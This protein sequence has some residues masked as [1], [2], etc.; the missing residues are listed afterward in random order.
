MEA[1]PEF[2]M[3]AEPR[4]SHAGQ[5]LYHGPY[6]SPMNINGMFFF[7]TMNNNVHIILRLTVNIPDT[8]AD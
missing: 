8:F 7:H 2:S 4:V 3:G 5:V 6:P 1:S